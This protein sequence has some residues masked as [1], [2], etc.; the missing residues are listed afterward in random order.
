MVCQSDGY[1]GESDFVPAAVLLSVVSKISYQPGLGFVLA[2]IRGMGRQTV[3][4]PGRLLAPA[5]IRTRTQA[6]KGTAS[7]HGGSEPSVA[8]RKGSRSFLLP[9][10]AIVRDQAE[11]SEGTF[12]LC[13][14]GSGEKSSPQTLTLRE[15]R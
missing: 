5:I 12:R 8:P 6:W 3:V 11:R 7:V 15:G 1:Q 10:R 13:L 4:R 2:L 9:N 14:T